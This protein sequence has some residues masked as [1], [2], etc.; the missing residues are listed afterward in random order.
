M[1]DLIHLHGLAYWLERAHPNQQAAAT[2]L[3]QNFHTMQYG[4]LRADMQS[5]KTG[6]Y[7]TLIRQ[8]FLEGHID[9]AYILC[10]SHEL[11]L[12][13]QVRDDVVAWHAGTPFANRIHVVFRQ[14]F[15]KTR[16]VTRR[17]LLVVD[18]SHLVSGVDQ[19]VCAFLKKHGLSMAG[20]T[21]KMVRESTYVLSVSATPF[22]EESVM[23]YHDS[24]PKFRVVLESGPTYYGVESY[25]CDGHLRPTF[26][27]TDAAGAAAFRSL[28]QAYP[29]KVVLVR[30]P[31]RN[32]QLQALLRCANDAGCIA[33]RFTSKEA[34]EGT[35][36]VLTREEAEA[37]R[38]RYGHSIPCLEVAPSQTTMV[39][40]D[41]RL[42][43]GKRVPKAHVG[44]VWELGKG[45]TDT[46]MQ[47]LMGRMCGYEGPGI[48]DVPAVKPLLFLPAGVLDRTKVKGKVVDCSE[49]QRAVLSGIPCEEDAVIGPRHVAGLNPGSVQRKAMHADGT[50]RIPCV[51]LSFRLTPFQVESLTDASLS[52]IKT[53]CLGHLRRLPLSH[54]TEEQQDEL[55]YELESAEPSEVHIRQYTGV[56]NQ[57]M[58]ASHVEA[59]K[60]TCAPSEHISDFH[61]LT[62]C[63]TFPGFQGLDGVPVVPGEVFAVF[64]TK[65]A[66]SPF[67]ITLESRIA[68]HSGLSHFVVAETHVMTCP[69]AAVYGFTPEILENAA[70]FETQFDEFIRLGRSGHGMYGRRFTA[71]QSGEAI[72][73]PRA[74]YGSHFEIMKRIL[75]KLE[76]RHSVTITYRAKPTRVLASQSSCVEWL[77]V[78]WAPSACA[79]AS[80]SL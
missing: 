17:T 63:V 11:E 77:S 2:S 52:A 12:L 9:Q 72:R 67:H 46:L 71:L 75:S 79:S 10:G 51:P 29:Q 57:N 48:Y 18:E 8:M 78:E 59:V 62:F 24:L 76:Q 15:K 20:T 40:I 70:A 27:L 31:S 4:L 41:G 1:R 80:S 39:L 65:S 73:L 69:A 25:L 53:M 13:N 26:S 22:V 7:Q 23:A 33:V 66:G 36:L 37:H 68:K 38:R 64:Y 32:K 42:R 50:E 14:H 28:L 60:H 19:S 54:L 56:S 45:H 44:F 61:W 43:C 74:V 16:M 34:D 35:Q 55:S 30:A 49:L 47:G 58:H 3:L 5:G 21:P 6:V